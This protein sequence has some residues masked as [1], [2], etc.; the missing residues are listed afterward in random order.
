MKRTPV[1]IVSAAAALVLAAGTGAA[2]YAAI[3]PAE[4]TVVRQVPVTGATNAATSSSLS[5]ADVYEQAH[6]SVVEVTVITAGTGFGPGSGSQQAQG[7]GFVYDD[8]GHIVTN[9]HVVD[10]AESISVLFSNGE[11]YDA[12]L[13]GSDASTDL[14]VLKVDAPASF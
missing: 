8:D 4:R 10:G 2:T 6:A 11:S 5:V 1:R 12:T 3:A 9:Q 14:A 13:V 7:S